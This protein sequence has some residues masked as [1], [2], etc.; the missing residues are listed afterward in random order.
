MYTAQGNFVNSFN[1]KKYIEKFADDT[2]PDTSTPATPALPV[3]PATLPTTPVIPSMLSA[4]PGI[5]PNPYLQ[6]QYG[7][8]NKMKMSFIEKAY[9]EKI[10][11]LLN[12][13]ITDK[14][15]LGFVAEKKILNLSIKDIAILGANQDKFKA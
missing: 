2:P 3:L 6:G 11:T 13:E 8:S 5:P 4:E 10:L 1:N 14:T 15:E 7:G 9:Y 12:K